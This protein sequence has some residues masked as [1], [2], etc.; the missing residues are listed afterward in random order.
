M[1]KITVFVK[2]KLL[3]IDKKSEW[4][5]MSASINESLT[6]IDGFIS[7]DSGFDAD[8]NVYCILKWESVEQQ[9]AF[10]KIMEEEMKDEMEAFGKICDMKT[11]EMSKI[12]LL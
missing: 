5:E 3:S 10:H 12:E 7:R 9:E 1:K 4:E 6:K 8:N 2:F 11:M